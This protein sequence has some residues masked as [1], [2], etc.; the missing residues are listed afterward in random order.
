[1]TLWSSCLT[2]TPSKI[3]DGSSTPIAG[4]SMLRSFLTSLISRLCRRA[5]IEP[6]K[7]Q[8]K[9]I[10]TSRRKKIKSGIKNLCKG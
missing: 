7:I 1:M 2:T 9:F 3:D 10:M 5:G 4:N 8:M 6:P